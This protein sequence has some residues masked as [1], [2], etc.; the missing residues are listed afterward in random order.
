M[1]VVVNRYGTD[2][3]QAPTLFDEVKNDKRR[4]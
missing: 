2:W 3:D 4:I 1:T